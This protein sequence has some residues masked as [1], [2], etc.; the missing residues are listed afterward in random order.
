MEYN[1]TR[2]LIIKYDYHAKQ[3]NEWWKLEVYLT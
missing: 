1:P 2:D 3:F